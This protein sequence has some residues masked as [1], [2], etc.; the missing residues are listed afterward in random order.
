MKFRI[1]TGLNSA[2]VKQAAQWGGVGKKLALS[3][4]PQTHDWH[5]STSNMLTPLV[6]MLSDRQYS[7]TRDEL[8]PRFIGF[9]WIRLCQTQVKRASSMIAKL[10]SMKRV[11]YLRVLGFCFT[12]LEHPKEGW[13]S[14][15]KSLVLIR[16]VYPIQFTATSCMFQIKGPQKTGNFFTYTVRHWRKTFFAH[17]TQMKFSAYLK[18]ILRLTQPFSPEPKIFMQT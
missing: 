9:G 5:N 10:A 14:Y 6:L 16:S 15:H 4:Q 1:L 7:S 8:K 3:Q 2:A 11:D 18:S 13:A 17:R 12:T